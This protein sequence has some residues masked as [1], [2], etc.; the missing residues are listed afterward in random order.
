MIWLN[1]YIKKFV[2]IYIMIMYISNQ[3]KKKKKHENILSFIFTTQKTGIYNFTDD[4][5]VLLNMHQQLHN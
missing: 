5:N 2:G 3:K 1:N 4:Y